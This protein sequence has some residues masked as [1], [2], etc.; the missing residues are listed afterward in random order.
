MD[1][2]ARAKTTGRRRRR[3]RLEVDFILSKKE[4]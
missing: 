2:P 4:E 1:L 3:I